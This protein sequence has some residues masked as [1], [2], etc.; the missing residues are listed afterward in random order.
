MACFTVHVSR[1]TVNNTFSLGEKLWVA[2]RRVFGWNDLLVV[3]PMSRVCPAWCCVST[4]SRLTMSFFM[5]ETVVG[6][7]GV[8]TDNSLYCSMVFQFFSR[9]LRH[10]RRNRPHAF[11]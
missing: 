8:V 3:R 6:V 2:N 4:A 11:C 7:G 9:P 5:L 10:S 1:G